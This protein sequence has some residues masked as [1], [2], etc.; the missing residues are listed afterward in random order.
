MW[1]M[2]L[3]VFPEITAEFAKE[4]FMPFVFMSPLHTTV[5]IHKLLKDITRPFQEKPHSH[6]SSCALVQQEFAIF[7]IFNQMWWAS[8]SDVLA[9]FQGIIQL[10]NHFH[11]VTWCRFFR[12]ILVYKIA[13]N[14]LLHIYQL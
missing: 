7:D 3:R 2:L 9:P 10:Q 14:I 11:M 1:K 8:S 12:L 5:S 4:H 13:I 6:I